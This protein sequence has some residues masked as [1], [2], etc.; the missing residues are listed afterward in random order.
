MNSF[1]VLIFDN[2]KMEFESQKTS[3]YLEKNSI[4]SVCL[5]FL[6]IE[7][8]SKCFQSLQKRK[9]KTETDIAKFSKK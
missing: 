9:M 8:D 2:V 3:D 1:V 4:K 5:I 6:K 7:I